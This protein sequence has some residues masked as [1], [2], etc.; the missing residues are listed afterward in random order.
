MKIATSK[1][2]AAH[3]I[4]GVCLVAAMPV[5]TACAGNSTKAKDAGDSSVP[6]STHSAAKASTSPSESASDQSTAQAAVATW[7]TA[8]VEDRPKKACLVMATPANDGSPAKANTAAMCN[9]NGP[10]ARQTKQRLHSLHTSFTPAQPK[11]PPTVKVAKVS[12]SGKTATVDG[13]QITVDGQTLKAIVL[14]HSS[15][16]KE[17]EVGV[18]IKAA[19]VDSRWYVTDLGLSV[20]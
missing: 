2:T 8:I 16:V 6:R 10:K 3:W 7:V 5:V 20:G 13:E 18:K 1:K 9:G 14:S 17:N 4:A 15:G 19:G 12:V 11:N